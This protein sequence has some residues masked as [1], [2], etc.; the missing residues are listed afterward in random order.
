MTS[1]QVVGLSAIGLIAYSFIRKTAGLSSL[2][3]FPAGIID[4]KFQG[5]TPV[6]TVGLAV[7]NTSNQS[8]TLQS[9][10]GNIYTNT[11]LVGVVSD[12]IPVDIKANAQTIVPIQIRLSLIGAVNDIIRAI[13]TGDITQDLQLRSNANIDNLQLPLTLNY[14]AGV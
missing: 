5:V 10:A 11:F 9:L 12:F 6:L 4:F 2:N 8:Y 13:T 7:Q 1:A 3:F 14:K